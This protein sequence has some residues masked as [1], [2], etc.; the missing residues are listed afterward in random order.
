MKRIKHSPIA[1]LVS[2]ILIGVLLTIIAGF[3]FIK[4]APGYDMY[5]VRSGSMEPSVNTGDMVIMG[6]NGGLLSGTLKPGKIVTY[7]REGDLITHRIIAIQDDMLVTKG[8]SVEE[9][10]PWMVAPED[11]RGVYI[12]KVPAVGYATNFM[13]TK[14]GWFLTIILPAMALVILLV[15]DV[16]KEAMRGGR[17]RLP[18][19]LRK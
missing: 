2:R 5:M 6:P 17:S 8:D 18:K 12:F 7:E 14:L 13:H 3:V 19:A 11:V 10:D 16:V 4:F 9:P 1:K 15:K